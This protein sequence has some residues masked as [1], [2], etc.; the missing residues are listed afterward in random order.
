MP[1]NDFTRNEKET[2]IYCQASPFTNCAA[3]C[4]CNFGEFGRSLPDPLRSLITTE[5]IK[6]AEYIYEKKLLDWYGQ[7]LTERIESVMKD[8]PLFINFLK[9]LDNLKFFD[10][11]SDVISYLEQ[12]TKRQKIFAIWQEMGMPIVEGTKSFDLFHQAAMNIKEDNGRGNLEE[13]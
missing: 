1:E 4:P 5:L 10:D 3:D 13:E 8:W 7:M 9:I 12:P 11:V 2:C 6:Q